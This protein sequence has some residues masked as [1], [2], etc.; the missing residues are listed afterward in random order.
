MELSYGLNDGIS[1]P[2]GSNN[3]TL[4]SIKCWC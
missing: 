1:I 3:G 4:T 2:R